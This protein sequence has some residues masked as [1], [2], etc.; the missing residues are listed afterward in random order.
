[1]LPGMLVVSQNIHAD[2]VAGGSTS[3]LYEIRDLTLHII[4]F[5]IKL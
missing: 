1:M 2:E 4:Y 3:I 5:L